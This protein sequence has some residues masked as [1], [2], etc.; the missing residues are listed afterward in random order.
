MKPIQ[1]K[2]FRILAIAPGT[3]GFGYAVLEAQDILVD[4]GVK[5]ATG[6]KNKHSVAKVDEMIAHYQPQLLVMEN[7]LA[8]D[9]RRSPRIRKLTRQIIRFAKKEKVNVKLFARTEVRRVFFA[10]GEGTKHG[11]AEILAK[12][13]PEELG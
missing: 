11:V 1:K 12:R 3:R 8:T 2:Y 9:S 10:V 4:W 13:F 5:S 6:D 7:H